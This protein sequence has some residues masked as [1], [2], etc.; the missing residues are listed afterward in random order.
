MYWKNIF[1]DQCRYLWQAMPLAILSSQMPFFSRPQSSIFFVPFFFFSFLSF[2]FFLCIFFYFFFF[3]FLLS[4]SSRCSPLTPAPPPLLWATWG[5]NFRVWMNA[6]ST[7]AL[8]YKARPLM[9][10]SQA[11][12]FTHA[13]PQKSS[14]NQ[15][16]DSEGEKCLALARAG[17]Y[18][19]TDF[20]RRA[21]LGILSRAIGC[22]S[23]PCVL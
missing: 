18:A 8:I 12:Q 2:L 15:P 19:A 20:D 23:L 4:P 17:S 3:L 22:T 16:E 21:H 1:F 7:E 13:S 5:E 14:N 10:S 6:D 11:T 9:S